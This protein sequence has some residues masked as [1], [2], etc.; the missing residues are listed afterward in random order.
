M[1][2][3]V[4]GRLQRLRVDDV[5]RAHDGLRILPSEDGC[6]ILAGVLRFCV[7]GPAQAP[8]EDAY[9]VRIRWPAGFPE[10]LPDAWET[11]GRI[12]D[13]HH[14]M[15]D[16]SLCLGAELEQRMILTESPTLP[17]FVEKLVI[18]YLF[19]FSFR[20]RHGT[21]PFDEL[22]HGSLGI[23]QCIAA[24]FHSPVTDNVVEFLRLAGMKKRR[25]NKSLCPCA[26]GRRLGRCHNRVVNRLRDR[27]GRSWFAGEYERH[28]KLAVTK[29]RLRAS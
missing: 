18:P 3:S 15:Y 19:G 23:R 26:S 14:K 22:A 2:E 13:D 29:T 4:R 1:T 21:M 17:T 10:A 5:L 16:G 11:G 20:Q 9:G 6:I 8:I 24:L 27:M 28:E 12:P 25:A 7:Q